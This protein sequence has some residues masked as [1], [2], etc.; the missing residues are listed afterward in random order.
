MYNVDKLLLFKD[1]QIFSI[2]HRVPTAAEEAALF[3]LLSKRQV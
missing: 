2:A 3:P 1:S